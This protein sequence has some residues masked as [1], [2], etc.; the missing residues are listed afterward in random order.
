MAIPPAETSFDTG[1]CGVRGGSLRCGTTL[2]S[3][4]PAPGGRGTGGEEDMPQE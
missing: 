4:T 1:N 2:A 3:G